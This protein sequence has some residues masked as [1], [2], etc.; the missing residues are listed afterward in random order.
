LPVAW[1]AS[2]ATGEAGVADPALA[3]AGRLVG[4]VDED[5]DLTERLQDPEDRLEVPLGR[6]HPLVAEVLDLDHRHAELARPALHQIG[7]AGADPAGDQVAHRQRARRARLEQPGVL[8]QPALGGVV[9]GDAVEVPGGLDEFEQPLAL[10]LDQLLLDLGELGD[11]QRLAG[12]DGAQQQR[13]DV[14]ARQADQL[15]S[16]RGHAELAAAGAVRNV[17]QRVGG[18][19]GHLR[20]AGQRDRELRGEGVL[21]H[22]AVEI[23]QVGRDQAGDHRGRGDR[24]VGRPIEHT[25]QVLGR[26]AGQVDG[27]AARHEKLRVVEDQGDAHRIGGAATVVELPRPMEAGAHETVGE[28]ERAPRLAWQQLRPLERRARILAVARGAVGEGR[29]L[30]RIEHPEP[31]LEEIG[32]L[33]DPEA[34]APVVEDDHLEG[35]KQRLL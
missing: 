22:L 15:A 11:G 2:S 24:R 3:L 16:H 33:F 13:A 34:L 14:G 29:P 4:L 8:A 27:V 18:V 32:A 17:G 20:L 25:D 5:D 30:E 1:S 12:A 7:L 26:L 10:L 21:D 19:L 28:L 31:L 35:R 6:P 9:A 23:V